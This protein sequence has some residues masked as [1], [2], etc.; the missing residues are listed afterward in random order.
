MRS[1]SSHEEGC[2][3]D[4]SIATKSFVGEEG[5]VKQLIATKVEWRDGK[6]QEINIYNYNIIVFWLF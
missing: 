4:W 5:K 2:E 6:M 3:R 1:S